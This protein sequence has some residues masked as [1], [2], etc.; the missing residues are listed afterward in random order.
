MTMRTHTLVMH[1]DAAEAH[2]LLAFLDQLRDALL[3]TYGDDIRAMLQQASHPPPT[4]ADADS[5]G[6]EF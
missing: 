2:T 5:G 3:Q 6:A 4:P 1:L